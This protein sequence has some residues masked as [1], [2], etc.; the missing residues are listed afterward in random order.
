MWA[1]AFSSQPLQPAAWARLLLSSTVT[2][3]S[4]Y[5]LRSAYT[6][7][8][9]AVQAPAPPIELIGIHT[10]VVASLVG[11]VHDQRVLPCE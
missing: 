5:P 9:M 2:D 6:C 1:S 7:S 8:V 4:G 11:F 3:S 10:E